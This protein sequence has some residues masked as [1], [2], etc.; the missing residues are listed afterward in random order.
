MKEN[1]GA[2]AVAAEQFTKERDYW[3]KKLSGEWVKGRFPYD[4][5]KGAAVEEGKRERE[6]ASL[7]FDFQ[8][9]V[10]A[11]LWKISGQSDLRLHMLLVTGLFALLEKYSGQKDM[12]LGA[13]IYTQESEAEFVNTMLVLRNRLEKGI[14]FKQ[15]LI[16]VKDTLTEAEEN[17]NYP[18]KILPEKLEIEVGDDVFPL[19]DIVVILDNIHRKEYIGDL[20]VPM[21]FSFSREGQVG[22]PSAGTLSA[23]FS[24]DV[25]L[26]EAATMESIARQYRELL[27]NALTALDTPLEDLA[28]MDEKEEDQVVSRFN[29]TLLSPFYTGPIHELFEAQVK[30]TPENTAVTASRSVEGKEDDVLS[31][32]TYD[33]LNKKANRLA[34]LLQRNG[35]KPGD[36]VGIMLEPNEE[37]TASLFGIMKTGAAYLPI[38]IGTPDERVLYMLEN[39]GA[40]VLVTES[41]AIKNTPFISLQNFEANKD[42][43]LIETPKRHFIREF[44]KLPTPDR[45]LINLQNYR[46]KIGMASVTNCISI[47]TTRGCP[48][49]CLYCHKI[50]AKTHVYRSADNIYDEVEYYYKN[51]VTNFAFIDDCFNLNKEKS[52]RFFN[53]IIRNKLKVQ[54]FF[55][56]GLR[57][58]ILTP[59]YIDTMVEA[60]T[61]GINLSL[62]TASPRLQKLLKKFLN[63]EKF[64][65]V[66]DY[67]AT[68]H[69]KV[70]LEMASM[71]GFPGETEEEAAMTLNFIKSIKWLHFPYIH[72]LKIF[73]N[74]EMEEFALEQGV[75][76]EAIMVSKDRA[77][78]E[79]PET[80]PFPKS[81]TR[82]YQAE[83]MNEY[84]LNKERLEHVLPHQMRVLSE[85]ALAQKYNAYLPVDI[86]CIRDVI[87][88]ARLENV[89]IPEGYTGEQIIKESIFDH[90]PEIRST[91][92]DAKKILFLDLSQHFSSHSM[93]YNVAEQP[94]GQIYLLSYL[95]EQYGD[96]IDGRIY[97]SGND[98]DS[99]ADLKKLVDDYQPDLV[100]IRCLTFFRE[101][102]HETVSMLRQWGVTVPIFTGGPYASS[103]YDTILKDKN[104]D[105]V[106]FGEGEYT[107][108]EL[109][110]AM[111]KNDFQMPAA[112]VL[113]GI[114][115]IAFRDERPAK[116]DSTQLAGA[117]NVAGSAGSAFADG[118]RQV[119]LLDRMAD[120][121][122]AEN[123]HNL[124]I[125][126][127]DD[128]L[129]YVMYTSGSTGRPKGV[130]VEHRQVNNCI[131]W[132]QD[133]FQ[134][135]EKAVI[136]NRTNLTFD[137]SVWE[138][139]WPLYI[140][141]NVRILDNFQRK[142]AG[143][144]V[145]LMTEARQKGL[146]MM[147]CPATLVNMM[148]YLLSTQEKK[149]VMTLPWLII[150]AEPISMEVV[151]AFYENYEGRIVNTYGPTECTINNTY[152][153]L[154]PDDPRRV[155]P[156]GK[157]VANNQIYIVDH[158]SRPVPVRVPGEICIAGDSLA[159][160]YIH[161]QKRTDE[162]FIDNPFG[163]GR[164]FKTGDIGRWLEDGTVEIMGRVDEQV[165]IRGYRIE[166][167][168]IEAI[169]SH[170][171]SIDEAVVVVKDPNKA[172]L[173]KTC[174]TCGITT[175][176]PGVV[177]DD[178]GICNICDL[179]KNNKHYIDNYFQN[180]ND[181]KELIT[182]A[183]KRKKGKYDACM[184]YNGGRGAAHALYRL[185]EMGFNVLAITYD[186]GYFSHKDKERIKQVTDSIGFDNM[187][188]QMGGTEKVLGE[189]VKTASTVCRGCFHV[190][191]AIAQSY[192]YENGIPIVI[193]A[194]LSR[195]Q[196]IENKLMLFL[197]QGITD[198]KE[199]ETE[200]AKIAAGTPEI[201]KNMFQHIDIDVVKTGAV[202]ETVK[203][204]DF[205]RYWDITNEEMISY[206]DN[207]DPYWKT[208][209]D[210]AIYSTNC[211]IKQIGDFGHLKDR[212]YHY[213]GGATS[214][215]VRLGHLTPEDLKRD[216][217]CAMTR[218]GYEAFLKRIGST[219]DRSVGAIEKYLCAYFVPTETG[220]DNDSLDSDLRVF[221]AK[222]LP[223]YMI[224][225]YFVKLDAIPLTPNGKLDKDALP[226]PQRG[227]AKSTATYVEPATDLEK[228]VAEIW[229]EILGVDTV[230]TQDNF[231][232]LGGNSMDIV[233]VGSKLKVVTKNDI[234]AVTLFTYPTIGALAQHLETESTGANPEI[235]ETDRGQ[236]LD[237]GKGR[238]KKS[239]QRRRG[240]A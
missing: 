7:T 96:R 33:E 45:G 89:E 88:F 208:R 65:E 25:Q 145:R 98:F 195:G 14:T 90:P 186:N 184:I 29:D 196:I 203:T 235:Q 127:K 216:L 170:H 230:G 232:D 166:P 108:G 100:G 181:L 227:R 183:G 213:Y 63:L 87:D 139:F 185:K 30:R 179:Y 75:S 21:V 126:V 167:G 111:F 114:Q 99:F 144:L 206:L 113:K 109:M 123:A 72:I 128:S 34:H 140:G 157:P 59:D 71:H 112:E 236:A 68:R 61:R 13:P 12:T 20:R 177:I 79:L 4:N 154:N 220:K 169:L 200:I 64:K 74:T 205:Y 142:D 86:K 180:P 193:G 124:N 191:S 192:A 222:E 2:V 82:K 77:F 155:V 129:A 31:S 233:M 182:E 207:R 164:M 106:A 92:G 158:Q 134:L 50:W 85:S 54:L 153:D 229:K 146:T 19:F 161:D 231:F 84:F 28:I 135:N 36:V 102:F 94:L 122:E 83:F 42:V 150:G 97:K 240:R 190:G 49:E 9:Q 132:M 70:I 198:V 41:S 47:Q 125:P 148:T 58:D 226:E 202:R 212:G 6:M 48:Y 57:G 224:P 133:K 218:K 53:K 160:G 39:A 119:I 136:V 214:W 73:P 225:S 23:E 175:R 93:L 56:N 62:E 107:L 168:E 156:I 197:Q 204:I 165:K 110:D 37:M 223:A 15:L 189:S 80:L 91:S 81:F 159:R 120:I 234:P 101:F 104:V 46:N 137:P 217:S 211:S 209:R 35:V 3:L 238:L 16:Q 201:D 22:E 26:Y 121:L 178:N 143:Y 66:M 194:T 52:I 95:K 149:P 55:P 188:M 18:I 78:H 151:K 60:G 76:K 138:I 199:L 67:I 32:L 239:M 43:K 1:L 130:M 40:K 174:K 10:F 210:Y 8:D 141:G 187:V 69:P 103:D 221:L 237:K 51:G 172:G 24:Y 11:G 116:S 173:V 219:I 105:L 147:Y 117:K 171:P 27:K 228:D 5:K 163:E 118:A 215:E 176:Y 17:Q 115:G 152:Y 38:D 131:S 44:D 162:L